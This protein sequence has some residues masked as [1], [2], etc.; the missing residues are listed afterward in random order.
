MVAHIDIDTLTRS[1]GEQTALTAPP[2]AGAPTDPVP[3]RANQTRHLVRT[4]IPA[5]L[6]VGAAGGGGAT[7]TVLGLAGAAATDIDADTP[8]CVDATAFGGDLAL[9]GCDAHTPI[10][11][12]QQ[13]LDTGHPDLWTAVDACTG[14]TSTGARVLARGADPLPRRES[15]ASVHR[16]LET[17]GALPIYDGGAPVA[18]RGIAP[19]L[20]DPRVALVLVAQARPDAVNR[21]RPA[22]GWLDDRFG[23]FLLSR[24]VIVLTEQI[25]GTGAPLADH[26]RTWLGQWVRAIRLLPF[27]PHLAAGQHLSW[28][29][30]SGAT[31]TEF[32]ILLGDLR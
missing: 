29:A 28:D 19:L 18:N 5:T 4:E 15:F 6:V 32:R 11:T 12:L 20:A 10:S 31:R 21:L 13:W 9:R 1:T 8:V 17:A 23:E 30:L 27:D 2:P 22:L 7:T 3:V 25:P 26:V 16:Y 24:A 14:T